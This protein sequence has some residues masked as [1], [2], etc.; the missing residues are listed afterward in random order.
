[1]IVGRNISPSPPPKRISA[2]T[3]ADAPL[4]RDELRSHHFG[5]VVSKSGLKLKHAYRLANNTAHAI[6]ILDLVNLKPCCGNVHIGTCMLRPG[7]ATEVEVTLS[8]RQ[9]FGEIVHG[10]RVLTDPAQRDDLILL[11]MAKAYAPIRIEEVT[12]V[13]GAVLLS[14]DK[15]K[16]V[17]FRVV[18]CGPSGEPLTNLDRLV[19]RSTIKAE[20]TGSKEEL[21]CDDGLKLQARRL[22]AV[23]DTAGP[24]GERKAMIELLDGKQ[25]VHSRVVSWDIVPRIVAVPK[26]VVIQ[27]GKREYHVSFRSRDH[28]PFRVTRMECDVRGIQCRA[29]DGTA[30]LVQ[31]VEIESQPGVHPKGG[32]GVIMV[33]TDHPSQARVDLP[34]VV[35]D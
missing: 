28:R 31:A 10:T 26:V 19:V 23:L 18:A 30:A 13:N 24:V 35:I 21:D 32:H 17:E 12:P 4:I 15:P 9:E 20:W 2:G 7:D 1:M 25:A 34:L 8:I 11:T 27:P 14:S 6:K 3:E 16:E 29:Q 22:A 5:A 33:S